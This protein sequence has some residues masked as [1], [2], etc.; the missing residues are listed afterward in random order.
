MSVPPPSTNQHLYLRG[1]FRTPTGPG[2]SAKNFSGVKERKQFVPKYTKNKKSQRWQQ[3][4]VSSENLGNLLCQLMV[5]A[6]MPFYKEKVVKRLDVNSVLKAQ[7]YKVQVALEMNSSSWKFAY[8]ILGTGAEP[9]TIKIDSMDPIWKAAM[10]HVKSKRLCFTARTHLWVIESI[11]CV[12]QIWHLV[13][14]TGFL[15]VKNLAADI[16]YGLAFVNKKIRTISLR[17]HMVYAVNSSAAAVKSTHCEN[18]AIAQVDDM[19]ETPICC[20]VAKVVKMLAT[21]EVLVL[22]RAPASG[23]QVVETRPHLMWQRLAMVARGLW[24]VTTNHA[25]ILL[26]ANQSMTAITLPRYLIIAQ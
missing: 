13:T 25:F 16:L 12:T 14:G 10:T 5:G 6:G 24:D 7:S 15:G 26:V 2:S 8:A 17:N 18:S 19:V 23:L 3:E 1:E 22:A 11:L 9:N 20:I 4:N 21:L